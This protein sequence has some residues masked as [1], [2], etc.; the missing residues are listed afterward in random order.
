MG[1]TINDGGPAFPIPAVGTAEGGISYAAE[2][3]MSLRDWFAGQALP[4]AVADYDRR[5]R[6]GAYCDPEHVL[7]YAT[8]A[9]G[10][11]EQIIARQAYHYADAMIAARSLPSPAMEEG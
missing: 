6:V 5:S 11:R 4:E 3:G 9:I 8:E 1:K 2:A 10:T 7:P